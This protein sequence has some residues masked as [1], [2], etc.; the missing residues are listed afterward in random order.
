M[1]SSFAKAALVSAVAACMLLTY[2][3]VS[4][5]R[6]FHDRTVLLRL[7]KQSTA[8][9]TKALDEGL[10]TLTDSSIWDAGSPQ[11]QVEVVLKSQFFSQVCLFWHVVKTD[12]MIFYLYVCGVYAC[13]KMGAIMLTITF[14]TYT[15]AQTCTLARTHIYAYIFEKKGMPKHAHMRMQTCTIT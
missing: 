10:P 2:T 13:T 11:N 1:R 5:R 15:S 14:S 12:G 9:R 4:P 3:V 8:V 7:S 6:S